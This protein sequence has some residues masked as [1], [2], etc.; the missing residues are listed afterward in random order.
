MNTS[1]VT[2]E[3]RAAQW[4]QIIKDRQ[5]SG[6]NVKNFCLARGISRDAYF[7]WQH[8]LRKAACNSMTKAGEISAPVVDFKKAIHEYL[9]PKKPQVGGADFTPNIFYIAG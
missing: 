7:Y 3:F 8:K 6:M 9:H 1:K 4:M 2:S 5:E